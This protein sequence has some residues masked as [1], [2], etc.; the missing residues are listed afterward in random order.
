MHSSPFKKH[1]QPKVIAHRGNSA[2]AP[3]N[4]YISFKEAINLHVDYIEG[5]VQLS[6]DGIPVVIHDKTFHRITGDC[7]PH[8]VNEL[9][10][11]EIKNIDAGSWFDYKF[12]DQRILTLEE[13]LCM[14]KGNIGMMLDIKPETVSER[15]LAKMVADVILLARSISHSFGPVLVGS[16]NPNTLL[17][18]K[19]YLPEQQF[20][21]I[22]ANLD[23]LNDFKSLRAKY[24]AL[25]EILA[26]RE[27]IDELHQYGAE[28][29]SWTVDDKTRAIELVEIGIDGL[30]TNQPKKMMNLHE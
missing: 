3:E 7:S 19:V 17:C 22:V 16:L 21:P 11:E 8:S 14:P 5:D 2:Q 27:L 10:L 1:R 6:K 13:F 30:I 9:N 28:V 23:H 18:L 25:K 24:Y 12:S 29:W 20:I 26:T 4:T 15:G